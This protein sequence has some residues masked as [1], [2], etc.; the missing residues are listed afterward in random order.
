MGPTAL[1]VTRDAERVLRVFSLSR[2]NR[3]RIKLRLGL[4]TPTVLTIV[5]VTNTLHA[6]EVHGDRLLAAS[7]TKLLQ[8][9]RKVHHSD[10]SI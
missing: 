2:I 3:Q 6:N 7:F 8:P 10:C 9:L 4:E 5:L 1:V